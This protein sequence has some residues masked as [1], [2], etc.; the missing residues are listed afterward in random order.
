MNVYLLFDDLIAYSICGI[1]RDKIVSRTKRYFRLTNVRSV[2]NYPMDRVKRE[3]KYI[4]RNSDRSRTNR[5]LQ[6]SAEY[7]RN[8]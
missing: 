8:L 5:F 6:L 7:K 1:E 2:S 4:G 3:C